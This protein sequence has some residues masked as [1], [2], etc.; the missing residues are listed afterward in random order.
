MANFDTSFRFFEDKGKIF[1][2]RL[3]HWRK[4]AKKSKGFPKKIREDILKKLALPILLF[5]LFFPVL[6]NGEDA[7]PE[8][9][10]FL[11]IGVSEEYT[12]CHWY[13]GTYWD[14]IDKM[15][16]TF[17]EGTTTV[18]FPAGTTW[19]YMDATCTSPNL[20]RIATGTGSFFLNK[21]WT[22]GELFL[23]F[24]S[25][26]FIFLIIFLLVFNF[27]FEPV[28]KIRGRQ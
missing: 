23:A 11:D 5:S 17:E 13:N 4:H 20:E 2:Y 15:Y 1:K 19:N 14:D 21:T 24:L 12:Q 26:V 27:Y 18:H 28:L 3:K 25:V 9:A 22:Y 7:L 8:P 16:R 6:V 10:F